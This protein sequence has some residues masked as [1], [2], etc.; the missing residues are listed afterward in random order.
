MAGRGRRDS[1]QEFSYADYQKWPADKRFEII[2]G[3]A[4]AMNAPLRIH[5]KLS[6]EFFRLFA[7]YLKGKPCEIYAAPFD[8]RFETGSKQDND[9]QTVVQPDLSVICD[10]SKLDDR[11]CLGAPDMIIE[12]LSPATMS[13]DNIKKRALYEKMGVKEFWLVHPT[14]CLVMA[15]HLKNGIYDKPEIFD[16]ETG[17]KSALFADLKIDLNEIFGPVPEA[18]VV[19]EPVA[20]YV[21]ADKKPKPTSKSSRGT[22]KKQ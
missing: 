8:V 11:G 15:Y 19:K 22:K 4:Y 17:A 10:H 9:I 21:S 6:G 20:R 14:D 12:V 7:N 3:V 13:Y 2:D 18:D 1:K 16:R 5:Q